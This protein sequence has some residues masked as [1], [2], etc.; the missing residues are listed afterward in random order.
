MLRALKARKLRK[1]NEMIQ[2]KLIQKPTLTMI[3]Q[4]SRVF[5]CVLLNVYS[6]D[7]GMLF[8]AHRAPCCRRSGSGFSSL[9]YRTGYRVFGFTW[10]VPLRTQ[11]PGKPAVHTL[12]PFERNT[13]Y[14]VCRVDG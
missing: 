6:E 12:T 3:Y 10:G 5:N 8:V 4:A 1:L 14:F 2:T 11:V 7:R 13:R 9:D